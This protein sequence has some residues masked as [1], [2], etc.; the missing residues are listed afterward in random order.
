MGKRDLSGSMMLMLT[1][2]CQ[3]RCGYCEVLKTP[4]SIS[5]KNLRA[6][7]DLLFT[8]EREYLQMRYFGGEPL[9][10]FDL[11]QRAIEYAESRQARDGKRVRHMISTN[12]L[13]LDEKKLAWL[14]GRDV[15]IMM[16]LDG[17]AA[18]QRRQRPAADGRSVYP[19]L[20]AN[21]R[22]LQRSGCLYFINMVV[23]PGG[24][25]RAREDLRFLASLGVSRVQICYQVVTHW[26]AGQRAGL[27]AVIEEAVRAGRKAGGMEILNLN[28]ECEPVMLSDEI[29]V[30]TDGTIVLNGA[31]FLER[32]L[33]RMREPLRLGR[34]GD[35]SRLA[36]LQRNKEE[37]YRLVQRCYPPDTAEGR[38]FLNNIG[39]G[40]E[41]GRRMKVLQR[42]P[43]AR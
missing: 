9:L 6:A 22:A 4:R 38:L 43:I 19:V 36:D 23:V 1:Y 27:L 14:S 10:R 41:V 25:E 21:L 11:L 15:E 32:G 17:A 29:L 24:H 37:I 42:E 39:F 26:D 34:L 20:R 3:L 8:G 12:G 28:N 35:G 2:A 30:D 13:L 40:L 5:W 7:M 33:P 18:T 31:V 16:S